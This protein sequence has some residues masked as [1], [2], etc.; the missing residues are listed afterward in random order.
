[1]MRRVLASLP[2]RFTVGQIF[3]PLS[4]FTVGSYSLSCAIVLSVAGSKLFP[5]RFTV[6]FLLSSQVFPVSL[7]VLPSSPVS[8]LVVTLGI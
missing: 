1:M 4:R 5:T 2:T 7:L 6:G 8:L 3:L